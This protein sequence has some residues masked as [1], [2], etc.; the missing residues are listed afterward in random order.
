MYRREYLTSTF[1]GPDMGWSAQMSVKED[2]LGFSTNINYQHKLIAFYLALFLYF[3]MF[4][5][6]S[7]CHTFVWTFFFSYYIGPAMKGNP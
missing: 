4:C 5:Y 3:K 7:V 6:L 2:N 1:F